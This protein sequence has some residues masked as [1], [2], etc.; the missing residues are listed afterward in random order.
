MKIKIHCC[1]E[2]GSPKWIHIHGTFSAYRQDRID[3]SNETTTNWLVREF[4]ALDYWLG[5]AIVWVRHVLGWWR[6]MAVWYSASVNWNE[7]GLSGLRIAWLS[8][9]RLWIALRWICRDIAAGLWGLIGKVLLIRIWKKLKYLFSKI[10]SV[11]AN[12]SI[13]FKVFAVRTQWRK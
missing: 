6:N 5:A 13:K 9:S 10:V 12:L 11:R 1:S 4:K 3:L 8:I 7:T 2:I